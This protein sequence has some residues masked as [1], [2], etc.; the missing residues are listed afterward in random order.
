MIKLC[1]LLSF[2]IIASYLAWQRKTRRAAQAARE[3]T[4]DKKA[5]DLPQSAP[6]PSAPPVPSALSLPSEPSL[7]CATAEQPQT[8]T[9]EPKPAAQQGDAKQT[10]QKSESPQLAQETA[11]NEPR[12]KLQR[13]VDIAIGFAVSACADTTANSLIRSAL[14]AVCAARERRREGVFVCQSVSC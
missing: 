1:L 5:G 8:A 4:A 10:N 7:S 2:I 14:L 6:Q 11:T 13:A 9:T 3:N 12:S